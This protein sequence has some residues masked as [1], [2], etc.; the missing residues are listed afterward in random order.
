M[1]HEVRKVLPPKDSSIASCFVSA[2][3]V[4]AFAIRLRTEDAEKGIAHL[5]HCFLGAPAP[6]FRV[7]IWLR[8]R[9][10]A[11]LHVKTSTQLRAIATAGGIEHIDFFSHSLDDRPRNGSRGE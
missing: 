10:V 7:L 6:W 11:D 4:D 8:D 3:L 2:D 5:A 9:I 1:S